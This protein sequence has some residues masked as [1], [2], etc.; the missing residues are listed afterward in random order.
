M[1]DADAHAW[2]K[3]TWGMSKMN[4]IVTIDEREAQNNHSCFLQYIMMF[5]ILS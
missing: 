3:K 5:G 1:L 4:A 2:Y